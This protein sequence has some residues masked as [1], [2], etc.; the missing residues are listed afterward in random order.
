MHSPRVTSLLDAVELAL[1]MGVKYPLHITIL[2]IEQLSKLVVSCSY[3]LYSLCQFVS[4]FCYI[5]SVL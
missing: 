3:F 5:T 4:V 1:A 2:L